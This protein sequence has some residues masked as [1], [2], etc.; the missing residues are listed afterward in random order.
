MQSHDF[1]I[2]AET[3]TPAIDTIRNEFSP[4]DGIAAVLH[5]ESLPRTRFVDKSDVK[6]KNLYPNYKN[7]IQ[8]RPSRAHASARG[9]LTSF[10]LPA[11]FGISDVDD[12]FNSND[13]H[14]FDASGE[15]KRKNDF[16]I[17]SFR[18]DLPHLCP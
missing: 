2:S 15:N 16:A 14:V 6:K 12:R 1:A 7:Y 3:S 11:D 17:N 13:W 5:G 18:E 9:T 10:V 4:R 8:C